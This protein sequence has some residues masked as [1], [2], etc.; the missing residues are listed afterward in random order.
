MAKVI[1]FC[2]VLT[3]SVLRDYYVQ[4]LSGQQKKPSNIWNGRVAAKAADGFQSKLAQPNGGI[5]RNTR[6]TAIC[7]NFLKYLS[8]GFKGMQQTKVIHYVVGKAERFCQLHNIEDLEVN[9]SK[10]LLSL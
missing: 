5:S 3:I 8:N 9:L 4:G 10:S 6:C 2:L 7:I 1:I